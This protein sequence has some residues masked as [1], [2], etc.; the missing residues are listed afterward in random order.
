[1]LFAPAATTSIP[2]PAAANT[3]AETVVAPS[4]P[5]WGGANEIEADLWHVETESLA[6]P[7]ASLQRC[8]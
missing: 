6:E 2:A 7:I 3:V 4:T 8:R 5:P 1:M